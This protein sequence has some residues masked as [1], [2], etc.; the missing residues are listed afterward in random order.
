MRIVGI[1]KKDN[2]IL[3]MQRL[4]NG[5]RYCVFPGGSIENN[6]DEE[7]ALKREMKEEINLII[8]NGK[9]L[10]EIENQGRQEKYYL[11]KEFEGTPKVSGPEKERMNEQ[12]QYYLEWIKISEI[13]K[14]NNLYPQEAV[15]K[16]LE[17]F[18]IHK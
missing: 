16:L 17:F 10:F 7:N 11:I 15:E 12:N 3:L 1:I 14:L 4:K 6:E 9:K 2:E 18:K 5:E 8:K 13:E